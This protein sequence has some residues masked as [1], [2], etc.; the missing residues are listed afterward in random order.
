[1]RL[2]PWLWPAVLF[3]LTLAG[4]AAGLV[5][6]DRWGEQAIARQQRANAMAARDYFVA[7]AREEGVAAL[8]KALDRHARVGGARGAYQGGFQYALIDDRGR[9]LAGSNAISSLDTPA[10]GWRKVKDP[11]TAPQD[12]WSVLAQPLGQGRTLVVAENLAARDDLRHAVVR[13]YAGAAVI[14]VLVAAIASLALHAFL[15]HRTR[16]IAQTAGRIVAGD[17]SARIPHHA[18][19]DAFDE[20]AGVLNAMLARIEELMV[21][22]QMVTDSLAHDLRSPLTRAKAALD[23]AAGPERE[24][25]AAALDQAEAEIDSVLATLSALLDIARAETGLSREMMRCVDLRGLALQ[26]GDL[27]APAAEDAGQT[28]E[29]EAPAHPLVCWAHETLLRQSVGNLLHNALIHAGEGAH[30]TLCVAEA[31]DHLVRLSV[32][33]DGPGIPAASLGGVQQ[34]FARL[35]EAR[36]RPG[37][38]LGLALVA[39]CAKLHRGRLTLEDNSPG[40]RAVLELPTAG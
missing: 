40:L 11:D 29:V 38:G 24:T 19:G 32:A 1:V 2:R 30:V 33:D 3:A 12:Q 16:A 4:F 39:A 31:G 20:L 5:M 35:D 25:H 6:V 14:A 21:G 36:S 7:F 18:G 37:S 28:L 13:G 9:M 22:M 8:A 26:M 15:L 23:R 34:R 17:L 27:F 10:A